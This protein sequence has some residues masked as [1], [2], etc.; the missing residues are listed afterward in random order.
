MSFRE[1]TSNWQ[2]R[3]F[4]ADNIPDILGCLEGFIENELPLADGR[5]LKP[6]FFH[7]P[8]SGMI[9]MYDIMA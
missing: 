2:W 3:Y 6:V 8:E 9:N 4:A 1:S 5:I 7:F